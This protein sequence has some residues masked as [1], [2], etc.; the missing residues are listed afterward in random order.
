MQ[1]RVGEADEDAQCGNTENCYLKQGVAE[2]FKCKMY[3]QLACG[4]SATK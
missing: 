2:H 3:N 1:D 4:W